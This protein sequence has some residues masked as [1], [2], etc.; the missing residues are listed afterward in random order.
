MS[1]LKPPLG[2]E[3]DRRMEMRLKL[4]WSNF[5]GLVFIAF[6]GFCFVHP[7]VLLI[8]EYLLP[9]SWSDWKGWSVGI[10]ACIVSVWLVHMQLFRSAMDLAREY[11]RDRERLVEI[12]EQIEK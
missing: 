1:D 11:S 4:D 10:G 9:E 3:L 2:M 7:A 5:S 8:H 6:V 12:I